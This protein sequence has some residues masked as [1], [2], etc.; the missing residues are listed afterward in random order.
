MQGKR[1]L[2][3]LDDVWNENFEKYDSL[4][5][6]LLG[7]NQNNGNKIIVTTRIR[8]VAEIMRAS[9]IYSLRELSQD[10]CW[11]LFKKKA[12]ANERIPPVL[13]A[14][15]REIAKR[16]KGNPLAAS[17][18]GGMMQF[19]EDES[20][21][22]S[23]QNSKTW[24]SIDYFDGVN[25]IL[26]LSFDHLPTPSLKKCFAY[27]S[28]FPKDF[29]IEKKLPVQLW[30]AEGFLQ[31]SKGSFSVMEDI[32]NKYFDFLLANSLFQDLQKDFCGDITRCKMHDLVHDLALSVSKLETLHLNECWGC[33][34]Y[35]SCDIRHLSLISDD[36]TTHAFSLS[37]DRK[38]R[39]RTVF[40]NQVDLGDKLLEFKC[41]RSLS[42]F[43]LCIKELP[44]SIGKL[45]HLRLLRIKNTKIKLIPNSVTKLYNLQ[46][47]VIQNC[48]LLEELPKDLRNLINLRHIDID[49][50]DWNRMELPLGMGR[51]TCLQTLPFLDIGQDIGG[52]IEELGCLSQLRGELS[53]YNLEHVRERRSQNCKFSGKSKITQIGILLE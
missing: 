3:I 14:I 49:I 35:V 11:L 23:I 45:R 51:L 19:K 28:I 2:L 47:L 10:E 26:K 52:R 13:E 29:V 22:L 20:E 15:G 36:H 16:C 30:M 41:V 17:V 6:S 40:L 32:G 21:W 44:E 9:F 37:K 1:Y 34:I 38:R 48:S 27:C 4:R 25:T 8:Y 53:I 50:S 18:L 39:L 31:T 12:F 5:S 42:L 33:D 46:T 43:G 7:I 24:G